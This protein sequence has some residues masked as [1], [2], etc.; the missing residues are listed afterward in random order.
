MIGGVLIGKGS[1]LKEKREEKVETSL[2]QDPTDRSCD[3]G[4]D[5]LSL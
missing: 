5:D 4:R 3:D 2:E 1:C